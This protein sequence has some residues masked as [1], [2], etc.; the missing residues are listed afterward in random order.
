MY[1]Q[2]S[3]QAVFA[4]V[5]AAF[6]GFF[7]SFA[8]VVQG[9]RA[10]GATAEQAALGMLAVAVAAG[11][12]GLTLSV[13]YRLPVAVA[14]STPGAAFLV[15]I[16]NVNGGFPEAVGAF[17]CAGIGFVLAGLWPPLARAVA[18][19]PRHIANA[20]LAGVLLAL[21]V[22]PL[23]AI[24]DDP[25]TGLT[26]LVAWVAGGLWHRLAAVPAALLA[27]VAIVWFQRAAD[28]AEV[29]VWSMS[30]E[31]V[32][33]VFS[34]DAILGIGVPL[35]LITMASQNVAGAA[36][37][38]SFGF[39]TQRAGRW[40]ATSG[41]FTLLSAPLGGHAVNLAALTAAIC[42]GEDAHPD[43]DRRY[44]AGISNGI[45]LAIMGL[46]S[47]VL[48]GFVALGP[49]ILIKAVAG[50]ALIGAFSGAAFAAFEQPAE[51]GSA[52]VTFLF[53]ASGIS[54]LGISGAFWGLLAGVAIDW[55]ETRKRAR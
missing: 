6:V 40:I 27:Y 20:M 19:I 29:M 50:L 41:I 26:V 43:P 51:R 17:I 25:A 13:R 44:W 8:V 33:P 5:V 18:R 54:L 21:C 9:L 32:E 36:V 7:G 53:A 34:A 39:P 14:W 38:S 12:C 55:L 16:G 3:A 47:G 45:A 28:T 11:L 48:I 24:G 52:A 2:F 22:A 42:A 49:V 4:G 10:A 37:I 35:F 15:T 31:F 46:G 30:F 1:A 23:E